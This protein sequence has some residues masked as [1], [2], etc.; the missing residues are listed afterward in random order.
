MA[1]EPE[2]DAFET[3]SVQAFYDANAEAEWARLER[4]RTEFAVTLRALEDHLP[5]PPAAVLDVGGGPGRYAIE[6]SRRGHRVTLVDL[7]AANL[8]LA[9]RKAEE[10]GVGLE[11]V[12]QA[13]ALDLSRLPDAA[14]DAVL[15]MG[16][17]YHL[18]T[19]TARRRAVLEARRRLRPGGVIFAAFITR[20]APLRDLAAREPGGLLEQRD[21]VERLWRTGV[22]DSGEGFTAAYFAHPDEIAPFMEAQGFATLGLVG[23]EGVVAGHEEKVNALT[24]EAWA[25]WVDLNYRLGRDPALLGASDHLLYIGRKNSHSHPPKS[26]PTSLK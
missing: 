23:C 7:A 22:H 8:E 19:E 21:Y 15:L 1:H 24:G 5:P 3:R 10:A 16:P 14:Y 6:L 11:G 9:R 13:N 2:N 18:L 26:T 17:L 20:F 25:R 4:H 12:V